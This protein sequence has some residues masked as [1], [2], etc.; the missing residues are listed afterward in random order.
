MLMIHSEIEHILEQL[1]ED[2]IRRSFRELR[3]RQD[4]DKRLGY[5]ATDEVKRLWVAADWCDGKAHELAFTARHKAN[6]EEEVTLL[7][8]QSQRWNTL[9]E[10]IRSTFWLAAAD[11]VGSVAWEADSKTGLYL[12][13]CKQWEL[14]ARKS[15]PQLPRALGSLLALGGDDE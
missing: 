14:V 3:E 10:A 5:V 12:A 15:Q 4:A 6:S 13:I 2:D 1:T 8:G 7:R 11:E 9:G